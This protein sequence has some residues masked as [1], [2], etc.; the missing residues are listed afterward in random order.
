M[1]TKKLQRL[2]HQDDQLEISFRK[3]GWLY[4][5]IF[6]SSL[7]VII[8]F[9]MKYMIVS[10][11]I[12]FVTVCLGHSVGLHRGVIHRSYRTSKLTR[13]I[14]VYLFVHMGFGGPISWL[15]ACIK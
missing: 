7:I 4:S 14:L 3:I 5:M 8:E 11:A 12:T 10:V 2:I 1:K 13:N 15:K 9:N 6:L